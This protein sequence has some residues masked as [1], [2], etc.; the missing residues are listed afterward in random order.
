[1]NDP[2]YYYLGE[3]LGMGA[4]K[5]YGP[6]GGLQ[7]LSQVST[8]GTQHLMNTI[9]LRQN[10]RPLEVKT[11]HGT[12]FVGEGAPDFGRP[13][14]N[15]SFERLTGTP[16]MRALWCGSLTR[17]IQTYGPISKPIVLMVGLPLQM[18][19]GDGAK[20]YANQVRG[21][22]KGPQAWETDGKVYQ[23]EIAE[24]KLNPQ[25]VGAL[26]DYVL[27]EEGRFIPEYAAL[28]KQE[29]GI[30]SIGFNTLELMVVR[31]RTPVERFTAGQTT[32]VRR[33]L[34]LM[35]PAGM[36]SL[37]ELDTAL[38]GGRLDLRQSLPI[39]ERELSGEIEKRWGHA[40]K[41]FA[42]ILVVGGGALLLKDSLLRQFEGKAVWP[43]QPVLSIARGLYKILLWK[44]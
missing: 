16:E 22:L 12:F 33:L 40:H 39:W 13:V 27:D 15:L 14:E 10:Q 9:G 42:R 31:D 30:V 38:R 5:L 3:D 20:E 24:V 35:N 18:L 23:V 37:G 4:N 34:D 41:R 7:V 29:I 1:M 17:F 6:A 28:F 43:D 32:G 19:S 26:F 25:P 21:W 2:S 36:Y 8:N 11:E 44:K